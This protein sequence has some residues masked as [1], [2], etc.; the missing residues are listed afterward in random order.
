[1]SPPNPAAKW[2]TIPEAEIV[3]MLPAT[4]RT[5]AE[6]LGRSIVSVNERLGYMAARGVIYVCGMTPREGCA[7]PARIYQAGPVPPRAAKGGRK[8][9]E[10]RRQ[11]NVQC[12]ATARKNLAE[13][14]EIEG[15]LE[16]MRDPYGLQYGKPAPLGV[17]LILLTV[18]GKFIVG[19]WKGLPGDLYTAWAYLPKRKLAA[20]QMLARKLSLVPNPED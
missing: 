6:E 7:P 15:A 11:Q 2:R 14:R 20:E 8:S 16:Q 18:Y 3:A 13:A 10:E 12:K 17:D 19:E 1:M 4:V 5:V 9:D